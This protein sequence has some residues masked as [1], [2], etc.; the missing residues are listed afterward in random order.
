MKRDRESIETAAHFICMIR[1]FEVKSPQSLD[2][3]ARLR[4]KALPNNWP[5]VSE[6]VTGVITRMG[7]FHLPDYGGC[8]GV[9]ITWWIDKLSACLPKP[10]LLYDRLRDGTNRSTVC[11]IVCSNLFCLVRSEHQFCQRRLLHAFLNAIRPFVVSRK[12]KSSS[13]GLWC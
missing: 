5:K 3:T 2:N 12:S 13:R 6:L 10:C 1:G 8:F 11:C 4:E 9:I 7:E